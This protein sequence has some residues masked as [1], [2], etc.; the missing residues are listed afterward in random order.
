MEDKDGHKQRYVLHDSPNPFRSSV[1]SYRTPAYRKS[2]QNC[3]IKR[4]EDTLTHSP[5]SFRTN[6]FANIT[7]ND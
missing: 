2:C 1:L 6:K 7:R 3:I 5:L 4:K